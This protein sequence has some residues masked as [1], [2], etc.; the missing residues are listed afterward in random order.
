[1]RRDWVARPTGHAMWLRYGRSMAITQAGEVPAARLSARLTR[2]LFRGTAPDAIDGVIAAGCFAGFTL[3]VL[4]GL[5]SRIGSPVAVTGFGVLAAAPLIVRRRWPAGTVAATAAVYV[6]ATLAGVRFTPWVS[7]AGPNLAIAVF[8]AADREPRRVSLAVSA[9]AGVVTWAVLPLA[10]DVLHPGQGQDAVQLAA[11]VPAWL[12]GDAVRARRTYRERLAAESRR[13]SAEEQGRAR[14]EERLRL[15]REVHDVISHNLS[16]IAVRSGVA[17]ML[18]DE[19]P[20]E[21]RA[22][23]AAIETTSRS[24]LNEIRNLLRRI[25]DPAVADETATPTLAELPALVGRLRDSGLDLGYRCTG[26]P[27][28]YGAA[29][30]LSAYRIAQEALTNVVKHAPGARAWLEVAHGPDELSITVTDDGP[31]AS[32]APGTAGLGITG[33]RERAALLGGQL[34]AGTRPEGGFT[35]SARLPTGGH[36]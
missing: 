17:R 20:A 18:L 26:E 30:E 10:M 11:V 36:Q 32:S 19:Q 22:A 33:M 13:R 25:R 15:S 12:A 27:A 23:L 16:M 28:G 9:L 3:P 24:A 6:A 5:A 2:R 8:T 7:N 35:V 31:G 1:M 21:A 4:T 34:T 14:A 29:L